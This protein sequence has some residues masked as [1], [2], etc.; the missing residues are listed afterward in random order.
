MN[1]FLRWVLYVV[2]FFALLLALLYGIA[3]FNKEKILEAINRELKTAINGDIKIGTLNFT[4]FENFPRFSIA[5]SD[6]YL[7]GPRYAQFHQDFFNAEKIYVDLKLIE[8]VRGTISLQTIRIKKGNVFI[9]RSKDGYINTETFKKKENK[10]STSGSGFGP[11]LDVKKIFFENTRINYVDSVKG[12]AYAVQFK[13]TDIIISS[14]D[15]SKQISILGA[16]HFGGLM[17][18]EKK[19]SY[20]SDKATDVKLNLE[21]FPGP[22]GLVLRPSEL[23]FDKSTVG[24]EGKFLFS[25]PGSFVL[26]IHSP[27]LDYLEGTTIVTK[28]LAEKLGKYQV[29]NPID[30]T[31]RLDGSLAGGEPKI[32]IGFSTKANKVTLGKVEIQDMSFDGTFIN[33]VDSTVERGDPNSRLNFTAFSGKISGIPTEG[34]VMITDLT[35]P[36]LTLES[37]VRLSFKEINT[38]ADTT[39][40]KFLSGAFASDVNYDGKLME[41][42]DATRTSYEGKLQG[43]VKVENASWVLPLQQKKFDNVNVDLQFTSKQMDIERINFRLNNSPVEIKGMMSGF[44]P[45]FFGPKKKGFVKL[46]IYSKKLDLDPLMKKQVKRTVKTTGLKGGRKISDLLDQLYEKIEFDLSLR[47]DELVKGP[48]RASKL[49]GRVLFHQG[50]LT[51][52]PF[53]MRAADGDISFSLKMD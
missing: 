23:Q 44:L 49:S 18:N 40:L 28:A 19:G 27:N 16:I 31:V 45:Y 14:T 29:S 38:Q 37:H 8:L 12:K 34:K 15:S 36:N 11:T 35:D 1:R 32:D 26:N 30:L 4:L 41:Y 39:R 52:G 50:Q 13:K 43:S 20:L 7:R 3:S 25:A 17:L 2:G 21:I 53:K 22:P 5:L 47:V 9:F 51:A 10:D 33:H 6:I 42:L 48:L 46:A 24:L